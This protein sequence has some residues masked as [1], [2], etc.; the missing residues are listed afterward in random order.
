VII[1]KPRTK[2]LTQIMLTPSFKGLWTF[3]IL[4]LDKFG[5]DD[6]PRAISGN[7]WVESQCIVAMCLVA[8]CSYLWFMDAELWG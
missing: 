1:S 2:E 7:L 6:V 4:K 3:G 8:S 5:F